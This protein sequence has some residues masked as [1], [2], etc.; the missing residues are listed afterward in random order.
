M[1][2]YHTI[3]Y[4]TILYYTITNYTVLYHTILPHVIPYYIILLYYTQVG[5]GDRP[6]PPSGRPA[7][8][9]KG[10]WEA[11]TPPSEG[12]GGNAP[13]VASWFRMLPGY[14]RM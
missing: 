2:P 1:I 12:P 13:G 11:A 14:F 7:P 5:P 9:C 4:H 3:P 8:R 6:A 10:V